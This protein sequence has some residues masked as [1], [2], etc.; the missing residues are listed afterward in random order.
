MADDPHQDGDAPPQG[1]TPADTQ[2]LEAGDAA[3]GALD[4]MPTPRHL[5]RRP[6]FRGHI[7]V[8][9]D[10]PLPVFDAP[11]DPPPA[12]PAGPGSQAM[13]G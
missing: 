8:D 4:D 6:K 9:D 12:P 2:R 10:E 3:P 7:V 1:A 11:P 5:R 13:Q